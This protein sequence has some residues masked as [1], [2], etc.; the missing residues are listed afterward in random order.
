MSDRSHRRPKFKLLALAAALGA[1]ASHT[2]HAADTDIYGPT[3]AAG[4][5]NVIFLLDNTSNWSANNQAWKQST[6]KAKC[7][8]LGDSDRVAVCNDYVTQIFG[9]AADLTQGQV[10]LRA[11]KL[12]LNE[13]VCSGKAEALKVNVGLSLMGQQ[14]VESN[15]HGVGLINFAVQELTG[16]A[17]VVGSS[18]QRIIQALDDID[19]KI[20]NPAYKA[21][22][23][24]NYGAALYE[25]FKYF[26][27][28]THPALA[29]QPE[30]NGATPLAANAYGQQRYSVPN[31]LD[32]V[33]AFTSAA[34][35]TYRSPIG[36]S[37]SCDGNYLVLVGNTYPNAEPNNGLPTQFQNLGYVP[38]SLSAVTSDTSRFA[39]EWAY[40]LANTDVSAQPGLQRIFTYAINTYNDKADVAQGKLMRS[41]AAVG[42]IGPGGY[43]EVGGDLYALVEGFKAVLAQIAA[44][45][46][47]FTATTLPVS[48]TTQGTFLNQIFVGMF[49]PDA[50]FSPRWVGNLK[51]Y[52]LGVVGGELTLVDR[53]NKPALFEGVFS[54]TAQSFWTK[55]SVYFTGAPMGSP[56]TASDGPDGAIVDKGGAAQRL[57][58]ANLKGSSDR[59]L[60]TLPSSPSD[61][62]SLSAHPYKASFLSA[63]VGSDD[64]INWVRGEN[65]VSGL[66]SKT[67][68]GPEQ[69]TGYYLDGITPSPLGASGARHSI[70]GDVLHSR[71]VALNYGKDSGGA[72]RVIVYYGAN[73]GIFRAVNGSKADDAGGSELWGFIPPEHYPLLKRLRA[74]AKK[75]HLPETDEFGNTKAPPDATSAPKEYG[76]DGPIG[77]YA[78]YESPTTLSK[79]Y[80]Y[81]T[82][83]R[84]GR[85][86]YAL[87]VTLPDAPKFKWKITGGSGDFAAL[88][89][90]WSM[91]K[92]VVTKTTT[93]AAPILIMGGGY[94]P[95]EDQNNSSGIGNVVY[96]VNGDTGELIHKFET[97]YSVPSDIT[98]VD[99]NGDGEPDRAYAVDVRGGV[100]RIDFPTSGPLLTK[101]SWDSAAI[102][103]IADVGGGSRKV[104]FAPDVVV[105][106]G[107]VAVLLGTGD[108]EKPFLNTTAD[109]FVLVKDT[110]GAPRATPLGL[111]D[112]TRVARVDANTMTFTDVIAPVNDAEGCYIDLATNGEKVVNAPF[113]IAGATYFGTNRPKPA[114]ATSC[115]ADLGQAFTY[116]FPLFCSVPKP[117]TSIVGGGMPPSPVGGIVTID[118]DGVPT[119]KPFIIGG[120]GPSPFDVDEPKPPV[121]PIRTRQTWRIDNSNR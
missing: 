58:E 12:V 22:S 82:M 4:S 38:P 109:K 101:A 27:G 77:V 104:F 115:S 55:D 13:L 63:L 53:Y 9:A 60:Y 40:F 107:F 99:V 108:R 120:S 70:H 72:D 71:P 80:I 67:N 24:A 18:C 75:L 45:N 23:S 43:L 73:D 88:A 98:V 21:P 97:A 90:T 47:V 6:V 20:Q 85:T 2:G 25:V 19:A 51:Q 42:G 66:Y 110:V 44:R 114:S 5:S 92:A 119:Q 30:P 103:K 56:A 35:T 7:D 105:T 64:E 61:G 111:S 31:V 121:P 91:P 96:I 52:Q 36:A 54:A 83:R 89:Q 78:L 87:D 14:S 117:P 49:R 11:L 68:L 95:A 10:Q 8:A 1:A 41:M 16:T 34:K 65:N 3:G 93:V 39:D 79:A 48:T 33:A 100:Y 50:N 57:R 106:K 76:M 112:L 29:G 37:N 84:G 102:V 116:Q 113:S 32:D 62:T 86:V 46:S 15:G 118:I 17:S 81:P 94:D 26:G 69:L 59:K 28:H 74:G